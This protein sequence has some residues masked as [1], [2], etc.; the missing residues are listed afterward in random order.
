MTAGLRSEILYDA[1]GSDGLDPCRSLPFEATDNGRSQ[2]HRNRKAE[3]RKISIAKNDSPTTIPVC[4]PVGD[5]S[6][7]G[8]ASIVRR[9]IM[10]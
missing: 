9:Y 10:Q 5:I 7:R 4:I 6:G 2:G 3:I 8:A 1:V